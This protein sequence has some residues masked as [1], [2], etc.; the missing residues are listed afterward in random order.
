MCGR[1]EGSVRDG[2]NYGVILV[3]ENRGL[4]SEPL[5]GETVPRPAARANQSRPIS[6][7]QGA[8]WPTIPGPA[9]KPN[10]E[11]MRRNG[12]PLLLE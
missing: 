6:G 2:E 11:M 8:E 9:K 4:A 1:D 12:M 7:K 5:I 3:R 10:K